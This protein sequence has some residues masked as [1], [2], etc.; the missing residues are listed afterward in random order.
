ML[1]METRRKV[2][3]RKLVNIDKQEPCSVFYT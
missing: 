2:R 3:R 1:C